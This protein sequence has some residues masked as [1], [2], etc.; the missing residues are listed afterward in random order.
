MIRRIT[1][2]WRMVVAGALVVA[3]TGAGA[4]DCSGG[5]STGGVDNEP[6]NAQIKSCS[7]RIYAP[8]A[9]AYF[10]KQVVIRAKSKTMCLRPPSHQVVHVRLDFRPNKNTP[11]LLVKQTDAGNPDCE[12]VAA[13]MVPGDWYECTIYHPHCIVGDWRTSAWV[14]FDTDRGE[15]VAAPADSTAHIRS[16]KG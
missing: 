14:V 8:S 9:G 16:C 1:A 3:L 10:H 11:W 2:T 5:G 12:K 6:P 4:S 7:L 13:Q 15:F